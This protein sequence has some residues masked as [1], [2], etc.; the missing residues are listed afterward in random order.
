MTH[1]AGFIAQE[2]G[3]R[4]RL[5]MAGNQVGKTTCGAAELAIY[6]TGRYPDWWDGRRFD[7][8]IVAWAAGV[9]AEAAA[10]AC[11]AAYSVVCQDK[12]GCCQPTSSSAWY[13]AGKGWLI[14]L[15]G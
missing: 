11:K 7:R 13:D 9:S 4:E 1:S 10:A 3:A 5:L 14:G 8:P 2:Y 15:K 6:L 12:P